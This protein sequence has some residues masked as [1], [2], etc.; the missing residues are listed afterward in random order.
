MFRQLQAFERF[1]QRSPDFVPHKSTTLREAL[2]RP[3]T[4]QVSFFAL[5]RYE[6]SGDPDDDYS[7]RLQET[8]RGKRLNN[9][10]HNK[11]SE[12]AQ[13]AAGVIS[14]IV[15]GRHGYSGPSNG[16]LFPAHFRSPGCIRIDDRCNQAMAS[17]G[18]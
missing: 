1:D 2:A 13:E 8:V 6:V 3:R 9:L 7:C 16:P 4:G 17:S 18:H 14:I 11:S 5:R 12:N 10:D 15:F